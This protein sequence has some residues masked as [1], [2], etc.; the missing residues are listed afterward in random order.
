LKI[1]I[2]DVAG[3]IAAHEQFRANMVEV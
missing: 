3:V 1:N 2:K